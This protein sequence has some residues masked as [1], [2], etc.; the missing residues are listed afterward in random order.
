EGDVSIVA[1]GE[2]KG[3]PLTDIINEHP[4]ELL[5]TEVYSRFGKVFPLL[6]KYLDAEQDLSIQVHPNDELAK[7]RHN[8]FGKTEM[9]YVLQADEVAKLIAGFNQIVNEENYLNKLNS[10]KLN[11]ILNKEEVHAG[12][13]F[14]LPAGRVH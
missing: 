1:N 9:W 13:I 2:L 12:D 14:F 10:G 3:K 5:G 8:S 11:D 6:F 7:K 4:V